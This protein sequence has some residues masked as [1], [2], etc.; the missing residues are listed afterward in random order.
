[1]IFADTQEK[2][3]FLRVKFTNAVSFYNLNELDF[4]G[5]SGCDLGEGGIRLNVFQFIPV[6]TELSLQIEFSKDNVL[7]CTGRVKW[8]EVVP[9]AERFRTGVKFE[10]FDSPIDFKNALKHILKDGKSSD[11]PAMNPSTDSE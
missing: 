1:M 8:V 2:R 5:C 4:G 9:V 11:D 3:K 6:E 10:S 7:H